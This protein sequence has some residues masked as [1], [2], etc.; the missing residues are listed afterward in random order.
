[1]ASLGI[2]ESNITRRKNKQTNP[3]NTYL[4]TTTSKDGEVALMHAPT[5]SN[6]GLGGEAWAASSVLGVRTGP[7]YT[8]DNLRELM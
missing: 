8:E 2:S 1:M 5:T 7:E 6:S 3:Q 4:T